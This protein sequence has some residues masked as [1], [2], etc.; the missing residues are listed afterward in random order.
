MTISSNLRKIISALLTIQLFFL[1]SACGGSN[2]DDLKK[3]SDYEDCKEYSEEIAA[4]AASAILAGELEKAN[5]YLEIQTDN[6]AECE[7]ILK[8]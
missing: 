3:I 7:R 2:I 1:L 4:L 6:D 8:E 5:S